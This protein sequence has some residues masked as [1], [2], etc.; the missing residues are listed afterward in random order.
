M[1]EILPNPSFEA[2]LI[3]VRGVLLIGAFWVFALAF[4]RWR[5][6]DERDSQALRAQLE[7][8]FAEVRS[9]HETVSVMSARIESMSERVET[10]SRRPQM[11]AVATPQARGYDLAMRMAKNG[12][13]VEDLVA[14]CGITRHE[15]ELLTRLHA[16]KSQ[17]EVA[18]WHARQQERQ[19]VQSWQAAPQQQQ[20]AQ[21]PQPQPTGRKRGSLL[22]VVG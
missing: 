1:F 5:R 17:P 12:S 10:D 16:A 19:P 6:A 4:T 14:N 15:A 20:V 11:A 13:S 22:S 21:A 2:V 9:L 3:A 18:N 8:T 7:R